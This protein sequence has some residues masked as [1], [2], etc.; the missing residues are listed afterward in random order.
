MK[1]TIIY[2][3]VLLALVSCSKEFLE[4]RSSSDIIVPRSAEDFQR[5]LDN[6]AEIGYTSVLPHLSADEYFIQKE[7]DWVSSRTATERNSYIWDKDVFGGEVDIQDWNAPYRTVFYANSII[8]GVEDA[9][10]KPLAGDQFSEVYGQA[11]FHRARANFDLL[12]NF[13]VPFDPLTQASDQGIPLRM[14]PSIDDLQGRASVQQG[15]M[16]IFGDLK[17]SLQ[18]L[19]QTGPIPQRNRPTRLAVFAQLSRIHLY[20]GE[21]DL[22]EDFADSVLNRYNSLID[23]NTVS[24]ES[25][26]PFSLT[27]EELIM[28]GSTTS[29][30]NAYQLNQAGAVYLDTV[31]ISIYDNDDLRLSVYFKKLSPGRY[32][33]KR[34]Y[35]G[36]GLAPFNGLA[37]DEVLLNKMECLVRRQQLVKASELYNRLRRN[38]YRTGTFKSVTFSQRASALE[39][40]LL[41]RRKELVWR[42]LRWDDIKRLNREGANIV[43]TRILNGKVHTLEPN[44]SRYVFNIPQDEINRSGISQN[45]R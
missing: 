36:S 20:R 18:Y 10:G 28:Y 4:E 5:L 19:S 8:K 33:M 40:V 39:L 12:K 42:S 13:S 30:N 3:I 37:V 1:R 2:I 9:V 44:S 17:A 38:R 11:L 29:Y 22:A 6:S 45:Q 16:A 35:N 24:K 25:N 43:L 31:L 7:S 41:E 14:D 32:I 15:Y 23:Y 34:G 21:Y 26:S 27:N